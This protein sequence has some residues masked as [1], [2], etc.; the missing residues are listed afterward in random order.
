MS[1]EQVKANIAAASWELTPA[2]LGEINAILG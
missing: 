2:E 1:P